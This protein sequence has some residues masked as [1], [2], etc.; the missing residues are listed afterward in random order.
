MRATTGKARR[1]AGNNLGFA[2]LRAGDNEKALQTLRQVE[3]EYAA[4]DDGFAKAGFFSNSVLR[5]S[6]R[7]KFENH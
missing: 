3:A 1:L 5:M 6:A 4:L 2:Q 7:A